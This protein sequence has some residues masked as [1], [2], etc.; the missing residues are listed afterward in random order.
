M[1]RLRVWLIDGV[2][3]TIA[4]KEEKY[5]NRRFIVSKNTIKMCIRDSGESET[6]RRALLSEFGRTPER[7]RDLSIST[8]R[9]GEVA[10]ALGQL[11]EARRAYGESEAL[12]RALLTEFGRTP[13]RLRDL[14]V[15][16]NKLCLL[17]TS[18]C[19]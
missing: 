13:E 5:Q 16:L 7:L 17:Y 4:I 1:S 18:R 3:F 14:S 9:Q 11:D 2:N 10:R 6:L 15:S 12:S 19:V 8:E